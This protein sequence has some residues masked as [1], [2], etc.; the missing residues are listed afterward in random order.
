MLVALKTRS[1]RINNEPTWLLFD[2]CG[3]QITD[4]NLLVPNSSR[5]ECTIKDGEG[6][7]SGVTTSDVGKQ[8]AAG[9]IKDGSIILLRS[10]ACN[11]I[12]SVHKLFITGVC[13]LCR[14]AAH[15]FIF[16]CSKAQLLERKCLQTVPRLEP[17]QHRILRCQWTWPERIHLS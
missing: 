16:I 3:M 2:P 12:G 9:H 4:L 11:A 1:A 17:I 6:S 5:Y 15:A 14:P 10:Y 8:V 7:I 13:F